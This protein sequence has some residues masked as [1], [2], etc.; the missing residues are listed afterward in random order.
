MRVVE[1]KAVDKRSINNGEEWEN[2]E[3][4]REE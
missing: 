2:R 1:R 3:L 4:K